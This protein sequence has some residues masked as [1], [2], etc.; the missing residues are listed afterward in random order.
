MAKLQKGQRVKINEWIV[1]D[2]SE[3]KIL[4]TTGTIISNIRVNKVYGEDDVYNGYI[5]VKLDCGNALIFNW[6]EL[7]PIDMT[8][9]IHF[10]DEQDSNSKGFKY[11]LEDAKAYI[12]A[13]NG[14]NE[15]YFEDYKGGTVSVVCNETSKTV[16]EELVR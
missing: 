16:Y 9:D 11:S 1:A 14:T 6:H 3:G 10:N 2:Q 4:T 15:S 5:K 13:Y 12:K 8:Y 7:E